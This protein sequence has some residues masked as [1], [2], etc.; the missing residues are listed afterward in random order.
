M[1]INEIDGWDI[2]TYI[3]F[4]FN[5]QMDSYLILEF[6]ILSLTTLEI[7]FF[8][9]FANILSFIFPLNFNTMKNLFV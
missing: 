4:K 3:L 7:L 5:E 6:T 1:N 2:Y 8:K 9:K